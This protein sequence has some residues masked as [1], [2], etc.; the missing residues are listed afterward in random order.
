MIIFKK[1]SKY[2]KQ[3]NREI[4]LQYKDEELLDVL[5]K[6]QRLLNEVRLFM[7]SYDWIK[8]AVAKQKLACF[9]ENNYD[10][11][12][13]MNEFGITYESTRASI[14]QLG[15]IFEKEIGIGMVDKIMYGN[16]AMAEV[17]LSQTFSTFKG[18]LVSDLRPLVP[19]GVLSETVSV[20]ECKKEI[21]FLQ[22]FTLRRLNDGVSRLDSTKLAHIVAIL[23]DTGG[24]Y[25][26]EKDILMSYLSGDVKKWED[27]EN[28]LQ[29]VLHY[30]R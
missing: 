28:L 8:Q 19:I 9:I 14:S 29:E 18:L 5:K 24:S 15:K 17:E 21:S 1:V 6:K 20:L 11:K 25:S 27:V 10:Y 23:E 3:I 13:V 26:L 7:M 12:I 22:F 4:M 2:L 30:G 16:I